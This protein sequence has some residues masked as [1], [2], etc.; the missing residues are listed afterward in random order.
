MLAYWCR[1]TKHGTKQALLQWISN[2]ASPPPVLRAV[3]PC[4]SSPRTATLSWPN[5]WDFRSICRSISYP[6]AD[7][8][9]SWRPV[10]RLRVDVS[11]LELRHWWAF[12]FLSGCRWG[13]YCFCLVSRS[14][15]GGCILCFPSR[16]SSCL[17]PSVFQTRVYRCAA[18]DLQCCSLPAWS[19]RAAVQSYR[20]AITTPPGTWVHWLVV[21]GLCVL[22]LSWQA[23]S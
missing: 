11:S 10:G 18:F 17:R 9:R 19:A 13:P 2:A 16:W 7:S 23:R 15:L 6:S 1:R 3:S 8:S 12:R 21:Q 14:R 4:T 5:P 22:L 20:L